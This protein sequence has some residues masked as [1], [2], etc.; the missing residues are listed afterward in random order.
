MRV[1]EL[2]LALVGSSHQAAPGCVQLC[3]FLLDV[4]LRLRVRLDKALRCLS[5]RIHLHLEKN[6]IILQ[7][8]VRLAVKSMFP[9]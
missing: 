6:N 3:A 9:L 5:K 7:K 1:A 4:I 2:F 8:T